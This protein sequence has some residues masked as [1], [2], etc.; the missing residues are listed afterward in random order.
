MSHAD[1]SS[2][3]ATQEHST[4]ELIE[5]VAEQASFLPGDGDR[6]PQPGRDA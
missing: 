5:Q 1:G 6:S 4:G 2:K 3:A